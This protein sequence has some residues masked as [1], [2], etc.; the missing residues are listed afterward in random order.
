[1][2]WLPDPAIEKF[3]YDATETSLPLKDILAID[4]GSGVYRNR[5]ALLNPGSATYG[6]QL[7]ANCLAAAC[8]ASPNY[9]PGS[10]HVSFVGAGDPSKCFDYQVNQRRK[11]RRLS[12]LTVTGTQNG[13]SVV[14]AIITLADQ[15]EMLRNAPRAERYPAAEIKYGPPEAAHDRLDILA[16]SSTDITALDRHVLRSFGFLEI[17]DV[18]GAPRMRNLRQNAHASYWFRVPPSR[19]LT[20]DEH[21]ILLTLISDFW[22]SLPMFSQLE[23]RQSAAEIG[24]VSLDHSIWFHAAPK[25]DDWLLIEADLLVAAQ[26]RTLCRATIS[27]MHGWPVATVVQDGLMTANSPHG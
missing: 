4:F 23:E 14:D 13:R 27:D 2:S 19:Y 9:A 12:Q 15:G 1:M 20:P 3:L 24:F 5:R 11:G 16:Q 18:A 7:A 26:A 6:G 25:C 17:R 8:A 21:Y 22:F 10:L